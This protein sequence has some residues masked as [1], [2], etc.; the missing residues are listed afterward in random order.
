MTEVR[1]LLPPDIV[2]IVLGAYQTA[3]HYAFGACACMALLSLFSSFFIQRFELQ[4][5]VR[6]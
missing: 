4:T 2:E 1:I 3:L 5:K 6:K